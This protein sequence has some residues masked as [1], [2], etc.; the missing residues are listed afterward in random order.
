[1]QKKYFIIIVLLF[2]FPYS[3][4]AESENNIEELL[5]KG[6]YYFKEEINYQ[7]SMKYFDQV[8]LLDPNNVEALNGKGAIFIRYGNFTAAEYFF[9]K[10][11]EINPNHIKTLNNKG[12]LVG[13]LE[14]YEESRVYFDKILLMEPNNTNALL[15]KASSLALDKQLDY[16]I[17]ILNIILSNDPDHKQAIELKRG[18]YKSFTTDDI[19]GYLQTIVRD[20]NGNLIGYME[21]D[22]I[23]KAAHK[24][25][26]QILNSLLI[27]YRS[28][29]VQ[30]EDREYVLS[31]LSI[32]DNKIDIKNPGMMSGT[33][34]IYV[35]QLQSEDIEFPVIIGRW[36]GYLTHKDDTFT[37]YWQLIFEK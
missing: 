31:F 37:N 9:D 2:I 32:T 35:D 19:D 8:L 3:N 18:L 12:T 30:S 5:E 36:H 7:E 6:T 4:F 11:L 33:G 15:N 27:Q 13:H 28:E 1:M 22:L 24:D 26:D 34:I 25:I 29:T 14:K 23:G 16:A 10:A 21:S 20:K 17:D